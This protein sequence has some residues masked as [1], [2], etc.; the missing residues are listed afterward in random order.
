M[1]KRID[2]IAII[3]RD[4][5]ASAKLFCESYGF[6]MYSESERVDPSGEFKSVFLTSGEIKIEL[7]SPIGLENSFSRFIEKRGEGFHH[8]SIEVDDIDKELGS[9]KDKGQRLINE[10]AD[11]V[12]ESRLA[13]IHPS[14]FNGVLL[15]LTQNKTQPADKT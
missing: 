5:E 14:S 11:V 10:K 7:I 6:E 2:H 13:F 9:L 3:V 8:I 15:E 1:L 4:I 12:N